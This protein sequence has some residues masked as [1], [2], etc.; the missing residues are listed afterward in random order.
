[1]SNSLNF[2][3]N[4]LGFNCFIGF[5]KYQNLQQDK[6]L[7][8]MKC[9]TANIDIWICEESQ[10]QYSLQYS[11]IMLTIYQPACVKLVLFEPEWEN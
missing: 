5:C 11:H 4:F 7:K 9:T 2:E 3:Y 8:S 6:H 10:S 1:M